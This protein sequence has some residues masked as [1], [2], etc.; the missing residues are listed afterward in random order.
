VIAPDVGG[1]FGYKGKHCAE[2]LVLAWAALRLKRPLKWVATR[3]ESFISDLQGR[4]HHT[5][6]ALALDRSSHFLGIRVGTVV[7]LGAYVSTMGSA[8]SSVIY[9][10]LLCGM[11][12]IAALHARVEGIFTNTLPTDAYR[13]AGRPEACYVLERLVDQ[14]AAELC[15]DRA[16]L[17]RRNLAPASA[18][19]YAT[20]A[21]PIYDSGDFPRVFERALVLADHAGY[22]ARREQAAARG[23]RLGLGIACFVESSGVGPSKMALA[24]GARVGL[25]ETAQISVDGAG[26]VKVLIGTQNHG[27][28]HETVFSQ[29]L[30]AKLGV[31]PGQIEIV[32]GDTGRVASGTGTFGSRSVAVGGSA[33]VLAAEDLVKAGRHA[34]ARAWKVAVDDVSFLVAPHGARYTAGAHSLDLAAVARL[35]RE[36]DGSDWT[37]RATFDPQSFAYSNGVHICEVEVDD[38]TGRVAVL[39]YGAVDDIGTVINPMI[40]DG[41]LQGGVAQGLGQALREACIYE[42]ESGQMLTGSLM[43]YGMPGSGDIPARFASEND[44]SQPYRL[45]PLGAKGAGEAGAIAAPAVLVNAVLDALR[46]LGVTHLEM[47]LTPARVWAALQKARVRT[48]NQARL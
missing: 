43:D 47:P 28:G 19:P 34:A 18:M 39:R 30:R 8:I 44:Q 45:N 48:K 21:G 12:R 15:I 23:R 13:G 1:G 27:Q 41:Q 11:Y 6:A 10:S 42:P 29:I 7:N 9:S 22:P 16:E 32:S 35:V 33:L 5:E 26:A 38:A 31:P 24:G 3:S 25:S 40:V 37:G 46:P 20:A 36:S 17:R 14:A 4:D 2:E